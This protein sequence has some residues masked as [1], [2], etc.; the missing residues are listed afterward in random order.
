ML[1]SPE[2]TGMMGLVKARR[3]RKRIRYL[4]HQFLI[5]ELGGTYEQLMDRVRT[6]RTIAKVALRDNA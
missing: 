2:Y 6:C 1:L 3:M 4:Y 5:G